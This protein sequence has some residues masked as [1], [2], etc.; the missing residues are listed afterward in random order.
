MAGTS[1]LGEPSSPLRK[2]RTGTRVC[3]AEGWTLVKTVDEAAK[4]METGEVTHAS[5][6]HDLGQDAQERSLTTTTGAEGYSS[7]SPKRLDWT[8]P[9]RTNS[10]T[11]WRPSWLTM[12]TRQTRSPPT[13]ATLMAGYWR[14]AATSIAR[15]WARPSSLMTPL[16]GMLTYPL[17]SWPA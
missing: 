2:P 6:D 4:L 8:G 14:S 3:V 15:G 5:L 1:L 9:L 12:G 7:L 10:V 13:L 16:A 11:G 17:T